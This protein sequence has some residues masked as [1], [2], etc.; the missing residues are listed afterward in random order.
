MNLRRVIV[1]KWNT[2]GG[3]TLG[4]GNGHSGADGDERLIGL[5]AGGGLYAHLSMDDVK[6]AL[7]LF[8]KLDRDGAG[9][10]A[11]DDLLLFW[12][13]VANSTAKSHLESLCAGELA[14]VGFDAAVEKELDLASFI[15]L[16]QRFSNAEKALLSRLDASRDDEYEYRM[17]LV[18]SASSL[19]IFDD[20][21]TLG[22][23]VLERAVGAFKAA[24]VNKCGSL[25]MT[26][27]SEYLGV[28]VPAEADSNNNGILDFNEFAKKIMPLIDAKKPMGTKTL[29]PVAAAKQ[30]RELRA[31]A[32]R[33]VRFASLR[34]EGAC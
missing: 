18:Q 14:T 27:A 12:W 25:H 7:D 29:D 30:A 31:T 5:A 17:L 20:V 13:H 4:N 21:S 24:D 2:K 19:C 28:V 15:E 1:N 32:G 23:D 22:Q 8:R 3:R 33:N 10:L 26:K 16:L 6:A 9:V 11:A 34:V